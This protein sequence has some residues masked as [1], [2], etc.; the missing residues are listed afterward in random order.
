M[1]IFRRRNHVIQYIFALLFIRKQAENIPYTSHVIKNIY[2]DYRRCNSPIYSTTLLRMHILLSLLNLMI[3]IHQ[4]CINIIFTTTIASNYH[5]TALYCS[6]SQ[7]NYMVYGNKVDSIIYYTVAACDF[8]VAGTLLILS[9]VTILQHK[10]N[11]YSKVCC[12]S[13]QYNFVIKNDLSISM[14]TDDRPLIIYSKAT[15]CAIKEYFVIWLQYI[16]KCHCWVKSKAY[17]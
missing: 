10:I 4:H 15:N 14:S 17:L 9:R 8:V 2:T 1:G 3:N 5:N 7:V 6:A 11:Y 16:F 12:C 13:A